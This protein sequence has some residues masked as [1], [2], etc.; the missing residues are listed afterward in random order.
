VND[1][2]WNLGKSGVALLYLFLA[3]SNA[4]LLN[5]DGDDPHSVSAID[6]KLSGKQHEYIQND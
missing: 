1:A 2:T 3:D 4:P 6:F 5:K